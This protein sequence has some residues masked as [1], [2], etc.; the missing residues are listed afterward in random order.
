MRYDPET[1]DTEIVEELTRLKSIWRGRYCH[2]PD[3]V[4][5]FEEDAKKGTVK[6]GRR[7]R[8]PVTFKYQRPETMEALQAKI[9]ESQSE[10]EKD[11]DELFE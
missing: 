4:W 6:T 5:F 11:L 1:K 3:A 8:L 7:F 9:M 2:I 10:I